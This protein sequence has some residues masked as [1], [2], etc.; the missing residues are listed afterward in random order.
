MTKFNQSSC[1]SYLIGQL[2]KGEKNILLDFQTG[3]GKT[4]IVLCTIYAYLNA[5]DKLKDIKILFTT[6]THQQAR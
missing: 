5:K 2:E 3:G 1:L 4:I 6:R